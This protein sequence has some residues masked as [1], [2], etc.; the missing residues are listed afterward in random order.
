MFRRVLILALLT[1]L[2]LPLM[3]SA[4]T[5]YEFN[6]NSYVSL[7]QMKSEFEQRGYDISSFDGLNNNLVVQSPQG[8]SIQIK[9]SASGYLIDSTTALTLKNV[10]RKSMGQLEERL[11]SANQH[12]NDIVYSLE[13]KNG[14]TYITAFSSHQAALGISAMEIAD[15]I[16]Q[17]NSK[18]IDF[19]KNDLGIGDYI[20][21][22]I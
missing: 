15:L 14:N 4:V 11:K 12:S 21:E 20:A 17:T 16:E 6:L 2:L 22:N 18:F 8:I 1:V 19:V 10:D 9:E 7:G 5:G 13:E 3:T